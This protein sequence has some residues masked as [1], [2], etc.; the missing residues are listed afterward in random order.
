MKSTLLQ[1]L[2]PSKGYMI[3]LEATLAERKEIG[4]KALVN[5]L[6]PEIWNML[7]KLK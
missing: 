4:R 3:N 7:W 5:R 2:T 1:N 6:A